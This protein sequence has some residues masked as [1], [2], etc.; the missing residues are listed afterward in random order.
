MMNKQL[1]IACLLLLLSS[2]DAY[3]VHKMA[4]PFGSSILIPPSSRPSQ[5]ETIKSISD[6]H[7]LLFSNSIGESIMNRHSASDWLYN[8]KS[9]PSSSV[10]RDIRSPVT[11][12]AVWSFLVSLIHK[13]LASSHSMLLQK[14][15]SGMCV[16]ATPHGFLMSI[17]GLLLVFRTN[18]SYQRFYVSV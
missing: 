10:L 11:T 14:L 5:H 15:A 8:M 16:Q 13:F 9:L 17:L 4:K 2:I 3:S 6:F 7:T 18:S 12:F 1:N